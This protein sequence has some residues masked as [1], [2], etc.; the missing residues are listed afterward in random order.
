LVTLR[1][2]QILGERKTTSKK[3]KNNGSCI[4]NSL[5]PIILLLQ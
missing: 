5:I 2:L 1:I 4:C 3:S